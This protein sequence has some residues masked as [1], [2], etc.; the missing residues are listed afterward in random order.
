M[1]RIILI[2]CVILLQH[3]TFGYSQ[4]NQESLFK[5]CDSFAMEPPIIKKVTDKKYTRKILD[6]GMTIGIERTPKGR[7]WNCWVGGGDNAD[8]FFLLAWSDNDGKKWSDT[9]FVIDPH[10]NTLPFKRRTIVGQLWTDPLGRLWLFMDQA[11][12]YF[13][14]RAGNWYSICENPDAEDPVW[15]TPQYIGFGCSLNKP[16]VMSTGEWVL[17]VSLW[18]RSKM[19]I[20]LER[21][22]TANPLREAHHELDS[23]RGAHAFVST[24]QGKT[25]EDRGFVQYPSPSFDE[26]QFIELQDGRWWMTARTGLGIYQSF[27][28]DKGYSW[29]APELY[30]KHVNSRHFIRRLD[31]GALLLVRHGMPDKKLKKRSH[32]RAFLSFDE[33]KT[34]HG[35]L[36]LDDRTGV[37]YPT[38]FQGPDGYIYISYDHQ[39]TQL[40]EIYMAKFSEDDVLNEKIVSSKGYLKYLI[41]KPGRVKYSQAN[42]EARQKEKAKRKNK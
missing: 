8:A 9:K 20:L 21:G 15:S 33:G 11:M 38:G 24:D 26:H 17:P 7:I 16:T 12:T 5:A 41:F 39:R 10:N 35:N 36:L 1:K 14:G 27:S 22:W 34:W 2:V 23:V 42:I 19:D 25:W 28:S 30:S 4:T 31:S 13:D 6:Y 32:L 3:A 29:S 40:G 18:P 37:S